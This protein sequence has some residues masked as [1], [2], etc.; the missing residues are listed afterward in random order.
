VDVVLVDALTEA[1]GLYEIL[2]SSGGTVRHIHTPRRWLVG[3][4]REQRLGEP[5]RQLQR[6]PSAGVP[7]VGHQLSVLYSGS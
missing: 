4:D 7:G 1:H 2:D 3:Q 5:H 6:L